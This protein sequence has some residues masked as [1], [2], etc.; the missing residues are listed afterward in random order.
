MI[1]YSTPYS[2]EKDIGKSYNRIMATLPIADDWA[3]ILDGDAMFTTNRF[4]HHIQEVVDTY[5]QYDL[6][7]CMTNRVANSQQRVGGSA[8]WSDNNMATHREVGQARWDELGSQVAD[9]TNETP[10]SGVM[11]M[12][13][14]KG[15]EKVGGFPEGSMLGIDNAIHKDY[16][17]AG[18]KV[19]LM[20]GV[21]VMH[22]YRGGDKSN[23]KHLL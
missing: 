4:G 5:P 6:L 23:I 10:L 2:L 14:R 9:I 7:T 15:W 3:C 21:Y 19:G 11:I 12:S 22:W 1:Y 18:L 20:T 13:T 17:N 8:V 16:A